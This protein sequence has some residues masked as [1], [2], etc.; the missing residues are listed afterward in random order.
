MIQY[1]GFNNSLSESK[2][3]FCGPSSI[4]FLV[5][6]LSFLFCKSSCILLK[7]A[8]FLEVSE[9]YDGII[10][11]PGTMQSEIKVLSIDQEISVISWL[12]GWY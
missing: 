6:E 4:Q 7:F 8:L 11:F 12:V 3:S 5:Q 1:G 10:F 9:W 2:H